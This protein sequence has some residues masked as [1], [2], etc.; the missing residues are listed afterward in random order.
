MILR[1]LKME[2]AMSSETLKIAATWSSEAL[3]M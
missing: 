3:K 2:T 1:N